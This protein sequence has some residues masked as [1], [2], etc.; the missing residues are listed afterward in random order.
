MSARKRRFSSAIRPSSGTCLADVV[1][2]TRKLDCHLAIPTSH[3]RR[4][5]ADTIDATTKDVGY[6]MCQHVSSDHFRE[7][8]RDRSVCGGAML[9]YVEVAGRCFFESEEV[10][11][12]F[13]A[14]RG[15]HECLDGGDGSD[16]AAGALGHAVHGGGGAGEVELALE[17]PSL[18]E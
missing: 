6:G 11:G 2:L 5:I 12:G 7:E 17:R 18:Q 3:C 15:G 10:A 13:V 16:A 8:Q 14:R 9:T 4:A 1:Q